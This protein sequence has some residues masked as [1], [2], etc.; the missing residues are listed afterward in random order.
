MTIRM[1]FGLA[2]G[3]FLA[4]PALPGQEA[5]PPAS[6]AEQE[7]KLIIERVTTKLRAGQR[8]AASLAPELAALDQL[9][10]KYRTEV[11]E[12]AAGVLLLKA[13]LY[14]QVLQDREQGLAV[15]QQVKTDFPGSRPAAVVDQII[16]EEQQRAQAEQAKTALVGQAAPELNFEWATR[17]GLEKLSSLQGKVVVLDF[18]A[19]W[20]GPCVASFPKIR[21]LT[22]HYRGYAVEVIG[23][24]SLQ[25]RV[26]GLGAKPID[27]R[28]DPAKE[29]NLMNDYVAAQSINWTVAFSSEPVFNPAFGVTGIPHMAI[30]GADGKVRHNGIHPGSLSLVEKTRLIDALL[31]EAGL[32]T[33]PA[34]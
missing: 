9:V 8:D 23:V 4:Q 25:G 7:V 11:A 22:D 2:L 20:C 3:L 5:S 17:E 27:C 24:T 21:E 12:E 31:Q 19:T 10:E 14:L 1:L 30:V 13:S 34:P 18:W 15:L 6:A 28:N 32:P 26:H 29:H 16:A 33:P